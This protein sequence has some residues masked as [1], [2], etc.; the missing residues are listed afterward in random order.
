MVCGF[1]DRLSPIDVP[2]LSLWP[3]AL[4][5][6]PVAAHVSWPTRSFVARGRWCIQSMQRATIGNI[7]GDYH[8]RVSQ[9][10]LSSGVRQ[11][12]DLFL[13]SDDCPHGHLTLNR[14]ASI[15]SHVLVCTTYRWQRPTTGVS[16]AKPL[17]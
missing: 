14:D 13:F 6:R 1:G 16:Q 3:L 9:K 15:I 11:F 2:V 12:A 5:R 8:H 17:A 7:L 10:G 4:A